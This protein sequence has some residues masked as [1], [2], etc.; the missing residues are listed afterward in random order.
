MDEPISAPLDRTAAP[1]PPGAREEDAP[2]AAPAADPLALRFQALMRASDLVS[3]G[4]ARHL[5]V[6]MTDLAALNHLMDA[7]PRGPAEL[8]G[9]LDLSSASATALTQR[10]EA[11]GHLTRRPHP[12]DRRRLV[13]EPT[14]HARTEAWLLLRPLLASLQAASDDLAPEE[15]AT[16]ERW[17]IAATEAFR[18]YARELAAAGPGS[19]PAAGSPTGSSRR[20]GHRPR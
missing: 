6:N 20:S 17:L 15:R 4:M 14:E 12:S 19:E 7:E 11:M 3:R 18:A 16:V 13:V 2:L 1:E 9:L 5:G 8:G 10:L